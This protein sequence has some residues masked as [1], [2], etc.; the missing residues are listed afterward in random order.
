MLFKMANGMCRLKKKNK[1]EPVFI[2]KQET[3]PEPQFREETVAVVWG[4]DKTRYCEV[5]FKH[6]CYTYY[7]EQLFYDDDEGYYWS[8]KFNMSVSFFDTLDKAK[9]AAEAFLRG[10]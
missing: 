8:P 4:E 1:Q 2:Q 3:P 10:E 6:G 9:Q 5:F 7:G